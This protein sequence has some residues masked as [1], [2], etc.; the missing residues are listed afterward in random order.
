MSHFP[1]PSVLTLSKASR[2]P[3]TKP[4]V[5]RTAEGV[6]HGYRKDEIT[7]V[8]FEG[9]LAAMAYI[10]TK[11]DPKRRPYDWYKAFVVQGAAENELPADYIGLIRVVPSQTDS[12]AARRARN[13]ALLAGI[14]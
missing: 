3:S 13:E 10:A 11:K 2:C 9:T 12:D 14:S 8:T 6:G 7:A 4:V 1:E 5:I